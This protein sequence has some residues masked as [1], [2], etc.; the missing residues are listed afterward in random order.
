MSDTRPA[1]FT[2]RAEHH[3]GDRPLHATRITECWC[4]WKTT[5]RNESTFMGRTNELALAMLAHRIAHL[6]GR[7]D[8]DG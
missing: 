1:A 4:G 8:T 2:E 6:E 5:R 7:I 3:P